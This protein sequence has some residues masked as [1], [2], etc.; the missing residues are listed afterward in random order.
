MAQCDGRDVMD[1]I[2]QLIAKVPNL[3]PAPT[4]AVELLGLF[5]DP[6]RDIDRV[7]QLIGHDPSLTAEVLKRCG[8]AVYG[9]KLPTDVFEA[10]NRLGFYEVYCL[11]ASVVGSRSMAMAKNS[12]GL[13]VGR[14]WTHAVT[15]A[16]AAGAV[17]DHCGEE[18]AAAFTSGL[19]HDV[20]KLIFASAETERYTAV[21]HEGSDWG[22]GL[23]QRETAA[24]GTHHAA[25]GARLLSRWCLPPSIIVSV[26]N[27]HGSPIAA[28]P[29]ARL[30]SCVHFGN[31]LAHSRIDRE[32]AEDD[33]FRIASA[34]TECLGI[35]PDSLSAI[36][37]VFDAG[38]KRAESLLQLIV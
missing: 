32:P 25:L 6:D 37:R 11:V 29:F 5:K 17:A 15:T 18:E 16:V 13:D 31:L 30:A 4:V 28:G 20:G 7:V 21:L 26:M 22:K 1:P 10:V 19:L 24:F 8:S 35:R 36:Q 23:V 9:G 27:H 14:L 2:D 38:M 33:L 34:A 3:P 12:G